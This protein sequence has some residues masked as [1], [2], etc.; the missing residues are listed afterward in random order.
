[1][2]FLSPIYKEPTPQQVEELVKLHK[3]MVE[4]TASMTCE[5][6]HCDRSWKRLSRC[7]KTN[8]NGYF[9]LFERLDA[10]VLP[11]VNNMSI[12]EL[13]DHLIEMYNRGGFWHDECKLPRKMRPFLCIS[14]YCHSKLGELSEPFLKERSRIIKAIDKITAQL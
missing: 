14:Y 13:N 3:E 12:D 2:K 6:R 7:C 9:G 1:M 5:E 8:C 11:I 4:L 10:L